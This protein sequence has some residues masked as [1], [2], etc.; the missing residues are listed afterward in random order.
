MKNQMEMSELMTFHM[1]LWL[2]QNFCVFKFDKIDELIWIYDGNRY[3]TLL[4]S[5]IMSAIYNQD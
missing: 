2:E 5:E 4:G 3:L 1:T